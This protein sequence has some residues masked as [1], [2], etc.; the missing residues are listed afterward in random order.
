MTTAA[1]K[2]RYAH[3][4]RET[5]ADVLSR[6]NPVSAF[7]EGRVEDATLYQ[8]ACWEATQAVPLNDAPAGAFNRQAYVRQRLHEAVEFRN[9]WY[10]DHLK[11]VA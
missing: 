6:I 1:A 5:Y 2:T 4:D 11:A 7:P 8:R 9:K 3:G 10:R